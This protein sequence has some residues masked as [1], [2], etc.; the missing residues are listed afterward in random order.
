MKTMIATRIAAMGLTV[1]LALPAAASVTPYTEAFAADNA[2]WGTGGLW[3]E[4]VPLAWNAGGGPDGA[5]YVSSMQ[6]FGD[7]APGPLDVAIFRGQDN[8]GSSDGAFAG[9]WIDGGITEFSFWVRHDAPVSLKYFVRFTPTGPN[10][11]SMNYRFEDQVVESG[12]WTQLTLAISPDTPGFIP[13]GGPGTYEAVMSNLGKIQLGVDIEP[14]AGNGEDFRF[15]L[16]LVSMQV[17]GP[18]GAAL[19]AVFGFGCRRRRH[20]LMCS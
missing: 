2:N 6:N 1:M 19:L 13:G 9:D 18:G 16:A 5:N 14:L 10:F 12:T 8:Y 3:N 15:D 4:Y 17:P 11:P 7:F 20:C